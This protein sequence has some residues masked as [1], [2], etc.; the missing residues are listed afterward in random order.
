MNRDPFN[1]RWLQQI[2]DAMTEHIAVLDEKGRIVM[3]NQT[4]RRFA[5]GNGSPDVDWRGISYLEV[6]RRGATEAG[7][8]G[9]QARVVLE[10][11]QA[12]LS[13]KLPH[14]QWEYPCH[15]PQKER[16]F[17]LNATPLTGSPGGAVVT[18]IEITDRKL[19]EQEILRQAHQDPLT[20]LANRRLVEKQ[21]LQ[22]LSAARRS[23]KPVAVLALDLDGFKPVN[24]TYGH[25]AGDQ[26]LK[27]VAARLLA[28]C[29][30][31]DLVARVGGDEFVVLLPG[32]GAEAAKEIMERL[33]SALRQPIPLAGQEIRIG[34]S[35]GVAIF[36][37]QA[38]TFRGL[39]QEADAAMYKAK[40]RRHTLP[41]QV[42]A[43][44]TEKTEPPRAVT[45]LPAGLATA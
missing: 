26:I 34:A 45:P 3:V 28:A 15:S 37:T 29:R 13:G 31:D 7:E 41:F 27:A 17:L 8:E 32:T 44:W 25:A 12:V 38:W 36:P 23:G 6:C 39:L 14:F 1:G 30:K 24:D 4:W 21:A 40:H 42:P 2:M 5:E 22:L 33:D 18:H 20:G 16:W 9:R 19:R 10:G 43:G 35:L 11:L